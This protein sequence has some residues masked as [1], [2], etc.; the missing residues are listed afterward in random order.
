M[1]YTDP[2]T[3]R[4]AYENLAKFLFLAVA[5]AATASI[6]WYAVVGL[7]GWIIAGFIYAAVWSFS[8]A[9]GQWFANK[10]IQ[11]LVAVVEANPIETMQT[12]YLD[13]CDEFTKQQAAVTEFE[14]QYRNVFDMVE[15]LQKTDPT[16]AAEFAD[17]LKQ[18]KYGLDSLRTEQKAA[19]KELGTAKETIEKMERLWKVANAMNKALAASAIAQ[20]KKFNEIKKAVAFDTVRTNL[21]RAFANLNTSIERRKNA[22][23]FEQEKEAKALGPKTEVIDLEAVEKEKA[24][25]RRIS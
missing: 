22:E 21:N 8:P 20:D 6:A 7:I 4:K 11:A 15:G 12:L 5:A 24:P 14:T 13:K 3:K 18:M 1:G 19:Q 23:F 17:E 10:R 9:V 25:I 2:E 16:E